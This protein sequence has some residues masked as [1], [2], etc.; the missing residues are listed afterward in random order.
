MKSASGKRSAHF[1]LAII[2]GGPVGLT[3]ANLALAHGLSAIVIEKEA[4]LF[5]LPRAIHF[6]GDVMR[7][8]QSAG[9]AGMIRPQ[10]GVQRGTTIYG[11]DGQPNVRL[12]F[13]E[14]DSSGWY[15]QYSFY[16]PL[17]EAT[18]SENLRGRPG[19]S[20]SHG[21]EVIR[22]E[23]DRSGVTLHTSRSGDEAEISARYVIACDGARSL[24]R[25]SL[26]IEME[27]LGD[28]ESWIV[29]DVFV[30][31]T[32]TLPS[33]RSNIYSDPDQ[34]AVYVPGPGSHRR[35]E[36]QLAAGE[37]PQIAT[38][39]SNILQMLRRW[40]DTDRIEVIR[41]AA[42]TFRALIAHR[43]RADRIFLAGD[44]A[45]LTPPFLGQG[46]GHGVRDVA[47]LV[48]KLAAGINGADDALLDSYEGERKPHVRTVIMRSVEVGRGMG[49][50]N[51]VEASARDLAMRS[52]GPIDRPDKNKIMPFLDSG[53][54]GGG[55]AAGTVL[56]QSI[57]LFEGQA[58][59]LDDLIG[60]RTAVIKRGEFD[61]MAT[62]RTAATKNF[63]WLTIGSSNAPDG[64]VHLGDNKL[65]TDWLNSIQA[66]FVLIRPDRYVFDHGTA[67]QARGII[68]AYLA[69]VGSK[70]TS[71]TFVG[72]ATV[73]NNESSE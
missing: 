53:F 71:S 35:F 21:C 14:N 25:S 62:G 20:V 64:S 24:S 67:E 1:D 41:Q 31:E 30:D 55:S 57:V 58:R 46:M 39:P 50:R 36:W 34:P 66:D 61:A 26:G 40:T 43:W 28:A 42:Y 59:K 38:T 13:Q 48:W 44:A 29:V 69:T 12:H 3:A 65:L 52:A 22:L 6:N 72:K 11:A 37:D 47:N 45:H 15:Q 8:F 49:L 60:A 4:R 16:Q 27:N 70:S 32:N 23:Q 33:D 54:I 63:C 19:V 51:R 2:G 73:S 10:I 18:L 7:V 68:E 9:L 17:L 56:P 5:P